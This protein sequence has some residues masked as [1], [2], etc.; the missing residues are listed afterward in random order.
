[1]S[2]AASTIGAKEVGPLNKGIQ[3]NAQKDVKFMSKLKKKK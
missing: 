1:M 3:V 2:T